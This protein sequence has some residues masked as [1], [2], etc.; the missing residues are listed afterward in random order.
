MAESEPATTPSSDWK[1]LYAFGLP[2]GSVRA[3]IA[4]IVF[5]TIWALLVLRYDLEVPEYLRDL[6]FI[7]LGHYFAV[8]SRATAAVEAGP[9]PLYLPRGSVRFLLIA[10]FVMVAFLLHRQERLFQIKQNPAVATLLLVFGFLLGVVVKQGGTWWAGRG[11]PTPR[12]FEDLR[13]LVSLSAAVLLALVVCDQFL[14]G[15]Q[16]WGLSE[17]NLGLGRLGPPHILAAIVGFYF[18]T[19]S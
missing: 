15:A 11:R 5:G 14:P 16:H 2:A 13:A 7:I 19:R 6:L 4:L 12:L 1:R 10:G 8:R 9:G 3:L 17:I 18:G